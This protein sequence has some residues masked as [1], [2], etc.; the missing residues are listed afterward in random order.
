MTEMSQQ[1]KNSF[2]QK[3]SR[4]LRASRTFPLPPHKSPVARHKNRNSLTDWDRRVEDDQADLGPLA[5]GVQ[6][7]PAGNQSLWRD[8]KVWGCLF[9]TTII[10]FK[11]RVYKSITSWNPLSKYRA[12]SVKTR[13]WRNKGRR[14]VTSKAVE[15]ETWKY[16]MVEG[17]AKDFSWWGRSRKFGF[18]QT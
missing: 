14:I 15:P 10:C 8:R 3:R 18:P 2:Q 17:G 12:A 1:T 7:H 11:H 13:Q 9:S 16:W 5:Q 4:F 6:V